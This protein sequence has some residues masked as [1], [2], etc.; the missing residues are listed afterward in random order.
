MIFFQLGFWYIGAK[1]WLGKGVLGGRPSGRAFAPSV[2]VV[3]PVAASLSFGT[4]WRVTRGDRRPH[5]IRSKAAEMREHAYG[6]FEQQLRRCPEARAYL[7]QRG[8][9]DPDLIG[10]MRIGYAPGAC[11]RAYLA[12]VGYRWSALRQAGWIDPLGRDRWFRCLTFPL[13][14]TGGLYGRSIDSGS[15]RHRFFPVPKAACMAGNAPRH[16]AA[17][18]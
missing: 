18:F 10:G 11:L 13:E 14:E 12:D 6:F 4:G 2:I 5:A 17:W 15:W 7:R 8:I 1:A 3:I 16:F 9:Y